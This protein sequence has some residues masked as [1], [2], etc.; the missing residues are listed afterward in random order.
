MAPFSI[1]PTALDPFDNIDLSAI[2]KLPVGGV[3]S[4]G[5]G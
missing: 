4:V 3:D 5:L 2:V 1:F